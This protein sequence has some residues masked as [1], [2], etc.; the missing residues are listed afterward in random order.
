MVARMRRQPSSDFR[1]LMRGIVVQNQMPVQG[2]RNVPIDMAEEGQKF[3]MAMPRLAL[4]Q[5]VAVGNI[6]GRKE[7]RGPMP[8]IIMRDAFDIT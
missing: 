4:R 2:G 8:T 6:E 1:M 3:L 5:D 7:G